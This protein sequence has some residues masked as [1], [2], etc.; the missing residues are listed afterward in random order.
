MNL[1]VD[2]RLNVVTQVKQ[3]MNNILEENNIK[4]SSIS[5]RAKKYYSTWKKMK[6]KSCSLDKIDDLVAIRIILGNIEDCY[7]ALSL[8]H[9]NFEP[10]ADR[11]KDYISQ[12]KSNGYQSLHTTVVDP[13]SK[14]IFEI[15]I[16]TEAMHS[17]AEFGVAS[18]WSYKSKDKNQ[19]KMMSSE[20]L[21]WLSD[22]VDLGNLK[23]SQDD[24][25][26]HVKLDIFNNR[27]FVLTPKE[28]AIDLPL[29]ATALD[30]AFRIH[31]DIGCHASMAKINGKV[32]KL[33]DE[34]SNGDKVEIL[35]D[36]KQIPKRDWLNYV[37][38][39]NAAKHIRTTLRKAGV[40]M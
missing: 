8:V 12:P 36:K 29:G 2:Q 6:D 4:N 26:K 40:Q 34:L 16:R 39:T 30:F 5:G 9:K 15:Q 33:S 37:K 18:H 19:D 22:L 7:T 28:D 35:T 38:T 10:K 27:I 21:K 11:M 20:S 1:K 24:Y 23:W 32:A 31:Y 3:R 13:V 17:F 14:Q 25:L